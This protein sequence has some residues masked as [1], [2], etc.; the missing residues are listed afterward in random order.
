MWWLKTVNSSNISNTTAQFHAVQGGPGFAGGTTEANFQAP[1][2]AAGNLKSLRVDLST[3]PVG[4]ANWKVEV[5]INGTPSGTLVVNLTGSAITATATGTVAVSA[6]DLL[7][8]KVTPTGTPVAANMQMSVEFDPTTADHYSYPAGGGNSQTTAP[9]YWRGLAG[10]STLQGTEAITST[11][12]DIV[13]FAG[14]LTDF[15]VALAVAPGVGKSWDLIMMLNGTEVAASALNISGTNKTGNVTGMSQ[16]VAAG[17]QITFKVKTANSSPA[18][19]RFGHSCT[20]VPTTSGLFAIT[21]AS[22]SALAA[23]N[24]FLLQEGSQTAA[25]DATEANVQLLVAPAAL[26][27]SAMYVAAQNAAGT[28]KTRTYQQR[29]NTANGNIVAT[30][31]G[32]TDTTASDTGHSDTLAAGNVIDIAFTA[33]ASSTSSSGNAWAVAASTQ[34]SVTTTI[35]P[36]AATLALSAQTA[37]LRATMTPAAQSVSLSMKTATLLATL[38]PAARALALTAATAALTLTLHPAAAS[39]TLSGQPGALNGI[40]TLIPAA[41]ALA[42]AGHASPMAATMKPAA[43][44]LTLSGQQGIASP[45]VIPASASLTLTGRTSTLS[46][47]LKPAAASLTLTGQTSDLTLIG[48]VT[49]G[50]APKRGWMMAGVTV[51]YDGTQLV[52]RII[53]FGVDSDGSNLTLQHASSFAPYPVKR[54]GDTYYI[55]DTESIALYGLHE[56]RVYWTDI[57]SPYRNTATQGAAN[58]TITLDSQPSDGDTLTINETTYTFRNSPTVEGDIRIG[59]DVA[60][61]RVR[62]EAALAGVDGLNAANNDVKVAFGSGGAVEITAYA[63]GGAGNLIVFAAE[64]VPAVTG[65]GTLEGGIYAT[66]T[67]NVLYARAVNELL[68]GRSEILSFHCTIANGADCWALPG[69][70]VKLQFNGVAQTEE[71]AFLGRPGGRTTYI[72]VDQWM[73][74]TERHD[75]STPSGVRQVDFV[76]ATPVLQ[77][78]LPPLPTWTDPVALPVPPDAS[79]LTS[80]PGGD[81]VDVPFDPLPDD[82]GGEDAT[83]KSSPKSPLPSTLGKIIKRNGLPVDQCCPDP[84]ADIASGTGILPPLSTAPGDEFPHLPFLMIDGQGD[85]PIPIYVGD[86]VNWFDAVLATNESATGDDPFVYNAKFFVDGIF[87][88]WSGTYTD[89]GTHGYKATAEVSFPEGILGS[90][91]AASWSGT[92]D[93]VAHSTSK[94]S[95]SS[96]RTTSSIISPCGT[97]D[98]RA[99]RRS[100]PPRH[101]LP[102]R[103]PERRRSAHDGDGVQPL[104]RARRT[105]RRH[106]A[107]RDLPRTWPA[108]PPAQHR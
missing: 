15:Y 11:T 45:A 63:K 26:K 38:K 27:F 2:S 8:I 67:A 41:A 17:D 53:P 44:S 39:L 93:G 24:R 82:P 20:I 104:G 12:R 40:T 65:D 102:A 85:R 59:P 106:D 88:G 22:T 36:S 23:S 57:K 1:I 83:P 7:T 71:A 68:K 77:Y 70:R 92:I 42:L 64:G 99:P 58:G 43:A 86:K 50:P 37:T 34:T 49:F 47:T 19:T 95:R 21:G 78:P 60:D 55:E 4:G 9:Q 18:A 56:Q 54:D 108:L 74:V 30:M 25:I 84:T 81:W 73:L 32:N 98:V 97:R 3:A 107:P 5:S 76:L 51:A 48:P 62:L 14:T 100:D 79:T 89:D 31:T 69:D 13:P 105:T 101:G 90:W 96:I 35:T 75:R 94:L 103:P 6:G 61:T 87:T 29:V 80:N 46:E 91:A 72:E 66:L 28:S 16:A 10:L 52:N 33:T